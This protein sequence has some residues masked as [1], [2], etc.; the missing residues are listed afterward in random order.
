MLSTDSLYVLPLTNFPGK[1][2]PLA[3]EVRKKMLYLALMGALFRALAWAGQTAL[4]W[5][6]GDIYNEYQT[7]QQADQT[8]SGTVWDAT[9][10]TTRVRWWIWLLGFGLLAGIAFLTIRILELIKSN[11]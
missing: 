9:R 2:E 7:T 10:R 11:K 1:W 3:R 5:M 6:F 8:G 4:G